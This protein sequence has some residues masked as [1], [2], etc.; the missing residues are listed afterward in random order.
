M[1]PN[2]LF[3]APP[4]RVYG[5]KC[6]KTQNKAHLSSFWHR[7]FFNVLG[8]SLASEI[9]SGGIPVEDLP[10][11]P[12]AQNPPPGGKFYV[13]QNFFSHTELEHLVVNLSLPCFF[14]RIW[15][16][17]LVSRGVWQNIWHCNP[18][19]A[20]QLP[21]PFVG[22][23]AN[24]TETMNFSPGLLRRRTRRERQNW[25]GTL[26]LTNIDCSHRAAQQ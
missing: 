18:H 16:S 14:M 11:P 21:A 23:P 8:L 17:T 15:L 3:E 2:K 20:G 9:L 19:W 24:P 10:N 5:P 22:G 4:G 12:H 6:S 1:M 13:Q 26:M 25:R 7:A